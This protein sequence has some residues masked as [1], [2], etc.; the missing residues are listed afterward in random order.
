MELA[1]LK[2]ILFYTENYLGQDVI[3]ELFADGSGQIRI[4]PTVP[5]EMLP[6]IND[7]REVKG[8]EPLPPNPYDDVSLVEWENAEEADKKL[9]D[10]YNSLKLI[11]AQGKKD[12]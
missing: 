1:I 3:A 12:G 9:M 2:E 4:N 11:R 10:F 6:F 7:M 8:A 5:K